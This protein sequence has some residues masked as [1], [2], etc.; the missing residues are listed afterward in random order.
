M[1]I[2]VVETRDYENQRKKEICFY[3]HK[4]GFSGILF[5]CTDCFA[6][7]SIDYQIFNLSDK[8]FDF[9]SAA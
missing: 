3:L 5:C 2:V 6:F 8:V 9:L 1:Q 7:K 4:K